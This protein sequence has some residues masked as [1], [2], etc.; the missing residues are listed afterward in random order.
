MK[1]IL[2]FA[3]ALLLTISAEAQIKRP[4]PQ[5][6]PMPTVHVQKPQE[7][8][9]KN[10]LKVMVVEDHKLPRVSYM[11][12]I[13]T[14]PYVE[15]A[16]AGVSSLTSAV[17]GNGTAKTSK[18]KFNDEIDFLGAS[19]NFWNTGASASG[20]SKYSSR[21]LELMAE[22]SLSP[23][24]SQEEFDK[25]KQQ[26]IEG[27]KSDEK[28][29]SSVASRVT[30]ALLF[31]TNH[32]T[33]EF[34]TEQS[35]N[36]V[37][38]ADV[39]QNYASYFVPENAYLVVVGDVKFKDVK[40][41]VE[42]LFKN[43]KKA[44][45][46]VSKYPEPVNVAKTQIDFV[47]MP[48]AVQSE[49]ALVNTV[50]LKLT[51]KDYF[52]ALIANQILGGGG[53]GRLFLNLREA[54]GWTYGAYSSLG[55]G[56]YTSKFTSSASV[57]NVVT[58]SAVVEFV[59][60]LQKIRT[61]PVTQAELDLAKA[62]YIGNF[63]METQKPGTIASFALRT[64]TQSLPADFYENYIKNIQAVTIADV[65][66]VANTYFKKDNQRIV[67]VGKGADVAGTLDRLGYPVNYYDRYA[68]P[69]EKPV[70]KKAAPAG[71]TSKS[72][73]ENHI[74]A[75]GGEKKLSEVK[76]VSTIAKGS[77]QGMEITMTQKQTAKGQ[78]MASLNGMGMELMKQVIT[79]T[80]GYMSGQGQ[81]Q[82]LKGEELKEA[83]A[84][85]KLFDELEDLKNA[86]TFELSGI[87]T[88]NGE[89]A[90]V[91]KKDKETVY[92]SVASG[93]K[94]AASETMEAQGQTVEMTTSYKD[95]KEVKGIKLPHTFTMPMLGGAEFKVSEIKINE[96]VTDADFK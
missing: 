49:I 88:F 38:L 93:L 20:L 17:V 4:Q 86:A 62:K 36:N 74:K 34:I 61:Q 35:L 43:W 15:G 21:L 87:E 82:E 10:G 32:P 14:P 92:Y 29:V 55:S 12:T 71:V 24:F 57:R 84:S 77:M 42:K 2:V 94:I 90:Y 96:G 78:M 13:D 27:L 56:K 75:I 89:E 48:N 81:K 16:K 40:K 79:P 58:D 85:A 7:F 50:N 67:I 72:V 31:G 44:S 66:R 30:N 3:S 1:K 37:T 54:H 19:V 41:Q 6:G 91:L 45:A 70:F 26:A 59:N 9:M 76:S 46:P 65:Q 8:T 11:L 68:N 39:K 73:I 5:P 47:D 80:M 63:V 83:Q 23:L 33:G 64:K 53:E 18:E 60:E 52:A 95:Y 69:V 25:S 28:S 22:G 51:D